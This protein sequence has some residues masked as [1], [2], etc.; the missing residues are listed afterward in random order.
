MSAGA[1]GPVL[2]IDVEILIWR[3]AWR[4]SSDRHAA[5]RLDQRIEALR[6]VHGAADIHLALSSAPVFRKSLWPRYKAGRK[7]APPR[8]RALR[9]LVSE[10]KEAV[11]APGLEADDVIGVLATGGRISG[12]EA[13][14]RPVI[15]SAD[16]DLLCVPGRHGDAAGRVRVVTPS[17]ADHAHLTQTLTGDQTDGYPGCPGIGP[18]H[19]ARILREAGDRHGWSAVV[20]AF[21]LAGLSSEQA[22]TQARLARILRAGEVDPATGRPCLWRPSSP[23]AGAALR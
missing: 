10:R 4:A 14:G 1:S 8:V 5:Q 15:L 21:G 18:K 2:L 6:R 13:S 22:L 3:A 9:A 16:K 11:R 19:A 12:V 17:A 20:S 7:P 23:N